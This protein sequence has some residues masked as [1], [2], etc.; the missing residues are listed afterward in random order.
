[1]AVVRSHSLS[2]G[3]VGLPN[4]GKSTLFNSLTK[5]AVP[6][7][8]FPFTTIDKN[9]G[10]V[11]VPDKK[12]DR[13]E[14]FFKA[15]KKVPSAITFVDIAGLVK[16][17][18]KGEGLGNQF[19]SHIREV[20]VV[21]Y[22]LRAFKSENIVHVY[23]RVNPKEDLDI[24]QSELILKD[25]DTVEKKLGELKKNSRSGLTP[26]LS[27]AIGVMERAMEWMGQGKMVVNMQMSEDEK[28]V[29]NELWLLSNKRGMYL[30]NVREGTDEKEREEWVKAFKETL[31]EED[32][33]FVIQGDVKMI[34]ELSDMNDAE[35]NEFLSLLETK[36]VMMEDIILKAY[37][38]LNL[39]TFYTG[40]E[41]EVNAWTIEGGATAK[42]AAGAIH[43]DLANRF[44]TAEVV[45]VE[46][47]LD[48]GGWVKAKEQGMVKNVGKDYKTQDGEYM[49]VYAN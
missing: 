34:G 33:G 39:I 19:L 32:R 14:E 13:L 45:D 17:A 8:N 26:E 15:Q 10:V 31:P 42:E 44:I 7:E 11:T 22:V 12:L 18:S 30:L 47:M 1:M 43:T 4:A 38:R 25:I 5:N 23:N 6:A 21:L 24:V 27:L 48:A 41:K 35:K 36:P 2:I 40:S 9:V 20:D 46:K 16:G 28:V 3:I 37:E 49:I 29:M